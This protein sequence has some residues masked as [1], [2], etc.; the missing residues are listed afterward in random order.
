MIMFGSSA[1]NAV[2]YL[3]NY[4]VGMGLV[5]EDSGYMGQ[6]GSQIV[7]DTITFDILKPVDL[8]PISEKIGTNLF[9]VQNLMEYSIREV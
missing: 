9:R 3:E 7:I 4:L 8:I 5:Y 2:K 6:P 1:F